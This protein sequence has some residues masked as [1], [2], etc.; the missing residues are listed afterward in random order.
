MTYEDARAAMITEAG[1]PENTEY[2]DCY[3]SYDTS[4][5]SILGLFSSAKKT[6]LETYLSYVQMPVNGPAYYYEGLGNSY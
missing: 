3:P 6:D 2:V 4:L 1:L 5:S